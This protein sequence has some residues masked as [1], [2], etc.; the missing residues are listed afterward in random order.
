MFTNTQRKMFTS[1]RMA[2]EAFRVCGRTI[3]DTPGGTKV[4]DVHGAKDGDLVIC[5]LQSDDTGE[6]ILHLTAIVSIGQITFVRTDTGSSSDDGV[7]QWILIR[8]SPNV[9][10]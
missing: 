3:L 9:K 7:V 5:T 8:P 2:K 10:K 4:I 6:T 1:C